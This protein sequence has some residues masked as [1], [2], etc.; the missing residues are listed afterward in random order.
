[1]ILMDCPNCGSRNLSEFRYGGE[2]RPRP[3]PE[4]EPAEWTRYVYYRR[5]PK[6]YLTEWWYHRAGCRRWFLAERHTKTHEVRSTYFWQDNRESE[7]V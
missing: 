4:A 5:N 6:D 3:A 2:A 7:P 1:M